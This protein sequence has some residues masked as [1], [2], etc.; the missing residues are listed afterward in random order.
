[1]RM[2]DQERNELLRQRTKRSRQKEEKR[3]SSFRE[4]VSES[5]LEDA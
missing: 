1:M 4:E 5:S 2:K 3:C